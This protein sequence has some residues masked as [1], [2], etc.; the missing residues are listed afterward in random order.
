MI[1]IYSSLSQSAKC[2]RLGSLL[3][4]HLFL[5]WYDVATLAKVSS[6]LRLA[7]LFIYL[8]LMLLQFLVFFHFAIA[9]KKINMIDYLTPLRN[10]ATH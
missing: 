7:A 9:E 2:Q 3:R 8:F 6:G 1:I 10:Y 5:S 4:R